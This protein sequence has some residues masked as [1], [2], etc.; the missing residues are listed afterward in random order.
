MNWQRVKDAIAIDVATLNS[1]GSTEKQ[2]TAS[3][4]R[5]T[6]KTSRSATYGQWARAC[7]EVAVDLGILKPCVALLSSSNKQL[8][9]AAAH[10]VRVLAFDADVTKIEL[11]KLGVVK[12]LIESLELAKE[13]KRQVCANVC[14][15]ICNVS[16]V[17]A[18][19]RII[20]KEG[21]IAV[22]VSLLK[23]ASATDD[24]TK[25]LVTAL[26]NLSVIP[27]NRAMMFKDGAIDLLLKLLVCTSGNVQGIAA[28]ALCVIA[29]D[30]PYA[31][32]IEKHLQDNAEQ[33]GGNIRLMY[34]KMGIKVQDDKIIVPL[35]HVLNKN[36][37]RPYL[38]WL[39]ARAIHFL[40]ACVASISIL[41]CQRGLVSTL[42][43]MIHHKMDILKKQASEVLIEIANH[44][45]KLWHFDYSR[46]SCFSTDM[47][48]IFDMEM[49]SDFTVKTAGGDIFLHKIILQC[50]CP[51]YKKLDL[52]KDCLDLSSHDVTHVRAFLEWLYT[53]LFDHI[54]P[55]GYTPDQ[56]AL[57]G[58]SRIV[59]SLKLDL[60]A[61]KLSKQVASLA[62]PSS[63]AKKITLE[64]VM[65]ERKSWELDMLDT[66]VGGEHSDVSFDVAGK[67]VHTHKIVLYARCS[68]F[69]SMFQS[70]MMES[71]KKT[72]NIP[73]DDPDAFQSLVHYIYTDKFE[74][75]MSD[76]VQDLAMLLFT[77]NA[78]DLPRLVDMCEVSLK[79]AI[80]IDNV[81]LFLTL[82]DQ[83]QAK[84]L[85]HYCVG[86]AAMKWD[87]VKA[88][89]DWKRQVP[90]DVRD[91]VYKMHKF[92]KKY[93]HFS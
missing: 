69:R 76:E 32:H 75:D 52:T 28:G 63:G 60:T 12:K 19:A 22:L 86:I 42:M 20:A 66:A 74:P 49:F 35:V 71:R 53:G 62:K 88:S 77:A 83:H 47:E 46:T 48:R 31:V 43:D 59:K 72:I 61:K 73:E 80:N 65:G 64:S 21:A 67:I 84:Q 17:E 10:T 89:K 93:A 56:K 4:T 18:N 68:Y 39:S 14:A 9:W 51:D 45:D 82:A 79:D 23:N 37:H 81:G 41:V 57:E 6:E 78:Y 1:S 26:W 33:V 50:R 15:I 36:S 5:I 24:F 70:G 40:G 30:E 55:T 87:V 58:M 2:K 3:L 85:F 25:K 44:K 7:R 8:R 91:T 38:Q 16:T 34:F 13:N 92:L 54:T 90:E 29:Q 11:V 27:E